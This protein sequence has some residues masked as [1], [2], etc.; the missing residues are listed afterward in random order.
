M[1]NGALGSALRRN[2]SGRESDIAVY[3]A[4]ILMIFIF[5]YLPEWIV[6]IV[7]DLLIN[8]VSSIVFSIDLR[9]E[10]ASQVCIHRSVCVSSNITVFA[11]SRPKKWA[12]FR[13]PMS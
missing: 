3:M 1:P 12:E 13:V 5:R 10:N 9:N 4:G 7:R 6:L 11:W 8:Y 2:V